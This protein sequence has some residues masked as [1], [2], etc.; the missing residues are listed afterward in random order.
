[1]S[2]A[3]TEMAANRGPTMADGP[4]QIHSQLRSLSTTETN[5]PAANITHNVQQEEEKRPNLAPAKVWQTERP[6]ATTKSSLL[7]PAYKRGETNTSLLNEAIWSRSHDYKDDGST[8]SSSSSE[9]E[10]DT[11]A[12]KKKRNYIPGKKNAI[13]TGGRK[14]YNKFQVGND[15]YSTRGKVSKRDGRLNISVNETSNRGYLAKALGATFF[16]KVGHDDMTGETPEAN[17]ARRQRGKLSKSSAEEIVT[18]NIP[19]PRLDI[20]VMVIGSRGDIQPFLKLGKN[21]KEYGH[22][23]RIATHPAFRDFVQNDSGLE[24]FSVGGDPAEL[25]AFMVKNPG[26]IPTMD[27]LKKGEVGRRREQMAEMFE[28][29]WRAC[30]N[31]T[32][33]EKDVTNLKMM[34]DRAPFVADAIIANPPCFAHIHCAERLGVPLHLMFTFPYTPTQAFP[35]PLANIKKT[36]VD[37][38]YTNFMSYPLVE[39]MTWQGLGDLVNNFRVKTLGLEPVSTLWAPGQ[40]YRL[41]VPYTYLWSPGLVPKP[42]DWG[43]EID[44]AGFVFLDLADTFTPPDDLV[45]F[46][47]DG[48]PPIY[49]GFGSIVVDDP[50]RFTEMIFEAVKRAGVRALVSKGWGGLGGENTPENVFMLENTPHDWLFPKVK[51]VVHHGGAGTTAIGLKCGKPTMIVPFFGD[52]QFWGSMIGTSGAGADPVPYKE[53]TADKLAEGIKQCLTDEAREAVEKIAKDIEV[54]G[55]GAQNA[56]KSF[57]RSLTLR[58]EH[59]MRCSILEDRVAVWTMKGT[60][61]RLSALA[62]ELLVERKKITWKQL[63]LIR[64]HEW[65]DFE[66]PGEPISGV[67]TAVTGTVTG[68]AAGVGSIPFKVRKTIKRRSMHEERKK[69]KSEDTRKN[70]SGSTLVEKKPDSQENVDTSN[71]STLNNQTIQEESHQ[72]ENANP[73]KETENTNSATETHDTS[74]EA[75][76]NS[77]CDAGMANHTTSGEPTRQYSQANREEQQQQQQNSQPK[78]NIDNQSVISSDPIHN[79][80]E[81][82]V[83]DIGHGFGETAEAVARAP[84]DLALALAQGFHNAPRLYGDTTVRRPTRITGMKS[85]LKAAGEEFIFGIYDGV[86]GLVVQPYTGARDHGALG[87][88]KGVGMG[89]TGFVLKDISAIVGPF[90]YTLKGVHK[91]MVKNKQPTAFIRRARILQGQR[92]INV[93]GRDSKERKEVE[94]RVTHGWNVIL[95]VCKLM[96]EKKRDGGMGLKGKLK[97]MRERRTWRS[98]GAFEG[99]GAAERAVQAK[100]KGDKGGVKAV[101]KRQRKEVEKAERPRKGVAAELEEDKIRRQQGI[102]KDNE[103]EGEGEVHPETGH[104]ERQVVI[105]EGNA[106]PEG[107]DTPQLI[108]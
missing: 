86:T 77:P 12:E 22:R 15:D 70:G 58:G 55:D 105:E 44:I 74:P 24:F 49:I 21:L 38:G 25:M 39:M 92:D 31:A 65:N 3:S 26:M 106:K 66:G 93:L 51:A 20:V 27:T 29:F 10:E 95:E 69:R 53:L 73:S 30:I 87:F 81:A 102:E 41:K 100:K 11:P 50:D 101:F 46:L 13:D 54:E 48:E 78:N 82:V 42:K 4:A 36:N 67:T 1:M 47:D 60:N 57:H 108:A 45:K 103:G 107:K 62:A 52:Q 40:L 76:V 5:F 79:E 68:I 35:H 23:V 85:G 75:A 6:R 56:V 80:A 83:K 84:M 96:D 8:S 72:D 33:E 61:L 90:G 99:V 43:P 16:N 32:D 9:D 71:T 28:G 64:H 17:L 7:A 63:R 91:E 59:S 97:V 34:G 14:Q 37:P 94:E 98:N 89:L 104:D 19:R 88:V 2:E 18:S